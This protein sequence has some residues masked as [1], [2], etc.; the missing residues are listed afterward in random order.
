[1]L[2]PDLLSTFYLPEID[3]LEIHSN[4]KQMFQM[5]KYRRILRAA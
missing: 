1:L 5:E 3:V 2:P 4:E